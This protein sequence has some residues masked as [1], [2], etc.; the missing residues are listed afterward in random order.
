MTRRRSPLGR[1]I[2][3]LLMIC[4]GLTAA[5]GCGPGGVVL[6]HDWA[7]AQIL[8]ISTVNGQRVVVGV[9]PVKGK[10]ESLVVIPSRG[11]D[12]DVLAPRIFEI[13]NHRWYVTVPQKSGSSTVYRVDAA[14]Q[15]LVGVGT[16]PGGFAP[17]PTKTGIALV[18]SS[19]E[20][21]YLM[22][23]KG[24]RRSGRARAVAPVTFGMGSSTHDQVCVIAGSKRSTFERLAFQGGRNPIR[25][26]IGSTSITAVD[27]N[28]NRPM[29]VEVRAVTPGARS[30]AQAVP[31]ASIHRQG[32]STVRLVVT[33]G[34]SGAVCRW[35]HNR[36][37]AVGDNS[38][39]A[40]FRIAGDMKQVKH[41]SDVRGIGTVEGL[42]SSSAGLLVVG[43]EKAKVVATSGRVAD[44]PMPGDVLAWPMPT[45]Q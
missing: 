7:A 41:V 32:V 4:A 8:V 25:D 1:M 30:P 43:D 33:G 39:T 36:I 11:D 5:A 27:C 26:P 14:S 24:W 37:V 13:S 6:G 16:I 35:G 3:L 22:D 20:D 18:S 44:I 17:L 9:D 29:L 2:A 42:Y 10:A 19:S 45:P 31:S 28:S 40:L 38:R 15:S 12:D 23:P 34:T 21:V